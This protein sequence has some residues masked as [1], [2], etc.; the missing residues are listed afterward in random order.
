[1]GNKLS[2]LRVGPNQ[3]QI[4]ERKLNKMAELE[5]RIE[6]ETDT[7]KLNYLKADLRRVKEEL[8]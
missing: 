6:K 1:M 4:R 2:T 3:E 5:K 7:V 8:G